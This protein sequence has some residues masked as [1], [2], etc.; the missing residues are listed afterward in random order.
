V[1]AHTP[2]PWYA[3]GQ[4]VNVDRPG[5]DGLASVAKAHQRRGVS[6]VPIAKAEAEANARL[7]AAAPDMLK[8]HE[9]IAALA[10]GWDE[11]GALG[12]KEPLSWESV[13][14]MAM[15]YARAAIAKAE[16]R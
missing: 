9:W 1:N 3:L 8:A 4:S 15:D 7:I 5:L 6:S 16:G 11:D 10:S 12:P 13:A 2:G 14:R